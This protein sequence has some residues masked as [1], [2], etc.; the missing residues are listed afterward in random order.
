MCRGSPISSRS[1]PQPENTHR[2]NTP[3]PNTAP[4]RERPAVSHSRTDRDFQECR[5]I[6]WVIPG[7][8]PLLPSIRL[9]LSVLPN[10][11]TH[12]EL[13]VAA[14]IPI[15]EDSGNEPIVAVNRRC[16]SR[17]RLLFPIRRRAVSGTWVWSRNRSS[18]AL[19]SCSCSKNSS[20]SIK[21]LP[22]FFQQSCCQRICCQLQSCS[23]GSR[24]AI[25]FRLS[26]FNIA[27]DAQ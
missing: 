25:S 18:N 1:A 16:N 6:P 13:P 21:L 9:K 14:A 15:F 22:L 24:R 27:T 20:H 19:S 8:L 4:G 2:Q 23:W 5:K 17:T 10:R 3:Q 26:F 11:Q 7:K 12:K